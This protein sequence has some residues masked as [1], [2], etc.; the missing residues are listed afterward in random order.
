MKSKTIIFKRPYDNYYKR[1][2]PWFE[3]PDD[4]GLCR[5][6]LNKLLDIPPNTKKLYVTFLERS[7]NPN[8]FKIHVTRYGKV[9]LDGKCRSL[10]MAASIL[11]EEYYNKGYRYITVAYED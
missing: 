7:V 1:Y 11:A 6:G 8:A 2:E 4:A 9:H 5:A 3:G 10:T